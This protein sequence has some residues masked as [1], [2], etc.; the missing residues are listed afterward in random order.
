MRGSGVS[1]LPGDNY[2][3]WLTFNCEGSS[4]I[5]EVPRV[6]G[7]SLK[8]MMCVVHSST[9]DDITSDGL[10][11][12]L[13]INCTKN[14]IQLYKRNALASF[15]DEE[16]RRVV[17][18]IEPG[19]KVKVVVVYENRFIVKKTTIYLIYDEAIEEKVEH[20]CAPY[21]NEIFCRGDEIESGVRRISAQVESVGD[22]KRKQKRRKFE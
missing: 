9:A 21:E 13:V 5:F 4:V 19:N 17:S 3:H 6:N 2:P 7:R 10:K 8:T 20:Y 11:N 12:V 15:E 18:N 22:L 1:L 16:W 14:T